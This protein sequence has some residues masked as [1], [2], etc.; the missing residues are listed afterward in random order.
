MGII[1]LNRG[2]GSISFVILSKTKHL[3][4]LDSSFRNIGTQ[5]DRCILI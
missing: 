3:N 2:S 4:E 1:L 5:N